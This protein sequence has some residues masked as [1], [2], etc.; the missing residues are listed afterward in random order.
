MTETGSVAMSCCSSSKE[1]LSWQYVL[2]Y[3]FLQ[4]VYMERDG[5]NSVVCFLVGRICI[6]M[7][8]V[9]LCSLSVVTTSYV[10]DTVG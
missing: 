5:C 4:L 1:S 6:N 3:L 2:L 10:K 7:L 9:A 8:T